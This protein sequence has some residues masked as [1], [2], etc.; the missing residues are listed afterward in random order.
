MNKARRLPIASCIMTFLSASHIPR[1]VVG[2]S[3]LKKVSTK[4]TSAFA[5]DK[6]IIGRIHNVSTKDV[7]RSKRVNPASKISMRN[8]SAH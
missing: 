1:M 2:R 6:P 4:V 5:K 3:D 7:E 8:Y